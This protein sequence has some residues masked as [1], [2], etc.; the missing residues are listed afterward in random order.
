[1][2]DYV[3]RLVNER[4][5]ALETLPTSNLRISFYNEMAEHHLFRWLGLR[6]PTITNRPTV[7]VGSDDPGIF[8]TN[9]KNEYAAI[10]SVLRLHF[11][12]TSA[13]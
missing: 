3:L 8:A 7:C 6:G 9:L 10:G 13:R 12:L 11:K 2:Q 1:M 4:G 5:V